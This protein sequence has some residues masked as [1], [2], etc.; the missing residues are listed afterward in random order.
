M[1]HRT[2]SWTRIDRAGQDSRPAI[3]AGLLGARAQVQMVARSRRLPLITASGAFDRSAIMTAAAVAATGLQERLGIS[4]REALSTALKAA[5][6]A[7]KM[8]RTLSAH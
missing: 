2:V 1:A 4:R 8:A 3:A 7:A 6:Q 5:W